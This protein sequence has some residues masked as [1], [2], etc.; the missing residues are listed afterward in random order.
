MK[1]STILFSVLVIGVIVFIA[2]CSKNGATGPQGPAGAS[3]T[4]G[5]SLAGAITGH[6]DL[7]DEYGGQQFRS[8]TPVKVYLYAGGSTTAQDSV[9]ADTAGA[10]TISNV[11]TG[12]Y[13]M[14]FTAPGYGSLVRNSFGFIGGGNVNFD[15]KMSQI[16]NFYVSIVSS[17]SIN[18]AAAE[19]VITCTVDTLVTTR[20]RELLVFIGSDSTVSFLPASYLSVYPYTVAANTTSVVIK[21]PLSDVYNSILV[22]GAIPYFSIYA[23]TN[24]YNTASEYEDL[25]TGRTVYTALNPRYAPTNT[26]QPLP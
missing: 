19:V 7:Y 1:K 2:S 13:T 12:T 23:A 24:N 4:P 26:H 21:I 5:P 17:D 9:V 20:Q 6:I 11:S 3:G 8:T 22:S 18:H 14:L 10:Y 16:P 15:A 25:P